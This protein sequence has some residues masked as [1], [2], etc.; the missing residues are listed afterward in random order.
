MRTR[1]SLIVLLLSHCLVHAGQV[2][3]LSENFEGTLTGWS[4]SGDWQVGI[5]TVVGPTAAFQGSRCIAT[6][7]SG[8]YSNSSNSI[9]VTP[10]ILVPGAATQVTLSFYEWYYLESC[11]DYMYMDVSTNGGLSW[12]SLRSGLTGYT[13]AW[14]ARTFDLTSYKG[15]SVQLRFRLTSDAS[16]TYAGWYID[17]LSVVASVIDT[18]NLPHIA[19]APGSFRIGTSDPVVKTLTICNTGIRD[20]LQYSFSTSTPG[21]VKIVAWT[22]GA[23]LTGEYANT[24]SSIVAR[25]PSATITP[26]TTTDPST[27][28]SLLQGANVFLIPESDVIV[29]SA[30][31]GTGFASVLDNYVSAGGIVIVLS[32]YADTSFLSAAGLERIS[33]RYSTSSGTVLV[34]NPSHRIFDSVSVGSLQ[35]L[36]GTAY[37]TPTSSATTLATY[38]SYPVITERA[39]GPAISTFSAL[40]FIPTTPGHGE[41]SLPIA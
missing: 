38:S 31:I 41:G 17:S 18:V 28:S 33:Y 16:G 8:N 5:P 10:S 39:R 36:N 30:S 14:L 37:W 40:I 12:T 34:T 21:S 13:S 4:L 27:L 26:T 2:T 11:C 3:L 20:T 29:P 32:P 6:N 22:Y 7:I 15:S 35:M 23:D 1:C 25:L 9:L 19:L 24:V